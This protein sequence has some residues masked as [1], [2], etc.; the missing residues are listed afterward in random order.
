MS[1]LK[2]ALSAIKNEFAAIVEDGLVTDNQ[3][4]ID[5]GS[6]SINALVSGSIYGGFPS[7]R[8]SAIAGEPS[9][10]KSFLCLS[11]C[12]IFL[13]GS[14]NANVIYFDTEASFTKDMLL[15]R[16]IDITRFAI[17]PVDTTD[18]FKIQCSQILDEYEKV[19]VKERPPLMIVLDSLGN[20][21]STKE[22]IDTAEGK[23]VQDMTR[24]K[25]IRAAFRILTLKLG[26]LNVPMLV[27]NH[28]YATLELYSKQIMGGGQGLNFAA[29]T[30]CFLS[31]RKEKEGDEI[32]GNVVHVKLEKSRLTKEQQKIDTIINFST[33]LDRYYGLL[34]LAVEAGIFKKVSTRIELPDGSKDFGSR[35]IKNPTKYFTQEVL[36]KID[37]FCRT[38]FLYG[39]GID[40]AQ[41]E[42]DSEVKV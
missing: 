19:P 41:S 29:S 34:D 35:I 33:G 31:K 5:S 39:N 13:N 18:S 8:V 40:S 24:G 21:A 9:T 36:D 1:F 30:I 11:T 22:I 2:T 26:K 16:G 12:K 10:G 17:I 4:Y 37:A 23:V 42:L 6:Y 15:D 28:T 20:L 7:N 32:I 38:K 27:T 3:G 25:S 14:P